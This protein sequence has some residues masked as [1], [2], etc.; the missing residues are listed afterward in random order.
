MRSLMRTQVVY[1]RP[2]IFH[3]PYSGSPI[4]HQVTN[5]ASSVITEATRTISAS[6]ASILCMLRILSAGQPLAEPVFLRI[7]IK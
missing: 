5:A 1:L 6:V 7:S 2:V 4:A 3:A